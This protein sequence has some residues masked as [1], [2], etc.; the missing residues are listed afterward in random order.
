MHRPD[1]FFFLFVFVQDCIKG[2]YR[3]TS[4]LQNTAAQETLLA[5]GPGWGMAGGSGF[6]FSS[7]MGVVGGI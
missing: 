1:F 7:E 6:P 5:V 4:R 3:A 2:L